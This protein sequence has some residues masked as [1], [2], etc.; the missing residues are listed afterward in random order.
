MAK[1]YDDRMLFG[2]ESEVPDQPPVAKPR[3][4]LDQVIED[5][6]NEIRKAFGKKRSI[7]VSTKM[8]ADA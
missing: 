5:T 3:K 7:K 1:F 4:T 8:T 6:N 2:L